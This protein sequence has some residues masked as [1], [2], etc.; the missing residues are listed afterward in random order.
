MGG[1]LEGFGNEHPEGLSYRWRLAAPATL[2]AGALGL[3][4]A[5]LGAD[6]QPAVCS[7]S[8]DPYTVSPETRQACRIESFPMQDRITHQ[9]GSIEYTYIVEGDHVN[10]LLPPIDFDPAKASPSE[11]SRYGIPPEPPMSD[12]V[13]HA[14]W[15]YMIHNLHPVTPPHELVQI[16]MQATSVE[17]S[18][19]WS[20]YVDHGHFVTAE[21]NYTEP[22]DHGTYCPGNAAVFWTGIGGWNSG[23]LAQDGTGIN[24]QGLGQHQAWYEI[25]PD[26]LTPLNFYAT[27]NQQFKAGVNRVDDRFSFYFYNYATGQG[28]QFT[29]TTNRYDDSTAEYIAERPVV[30]PNEGQP[31]YTPLT[32]FGHFFQNS[33]KSN[34]NPQQDVSNTAVTMYDGSRTYAVPTGINNSMGGFAISWKNC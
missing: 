7:T 25:L 4:P 34:G 15:E 29:V 11:L 5:A 31:Y 23:E 9:D 30:V 19:S 27:E 10:F 26:T 17:F 2:I 28:M 8:F 20:G 21:G 6:Q 12:E 18:D 33:A 22:S 3:A 32:N 16:P 24:L 1:K 13:G 14:A